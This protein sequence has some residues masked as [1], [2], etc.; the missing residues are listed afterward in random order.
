MTH[1]NTQ[2]RDNK[3]LHL[4]N[5][6]NYYIIAKVKIVKKDLFS[7]NILIVEFRTIQA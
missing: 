3:Q 5:Y 2:K 6:I 1:E 4:R 7:L